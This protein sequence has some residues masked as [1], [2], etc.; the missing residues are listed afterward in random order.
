MLCQ[1]TLDT[2]L[3]AREIV[4]RNARYTP[5]LSSTRCSDMLGHPVHFK[6]ENLQR[7]G[8][9][10]IR[11]AGYKLAKLAASPD[12]PAPG[13]RRAVMAIS[14]GNHAQGVALAS[15]LNGI[16]STV[17]MPE[18][19]PLS[20][21]QATVRYGAEVIC[22]GQT[23][24]E[25]REHAMEWLKE[26][27]VTFVSPFDD[28]DI[29]TGQGSCGLEILEQLPE[30]K[31]VV[32][33]VGGG[34][35]ISGIAIAIKSQ[36]PDIKLIGIQ[37][38]SVPSLA[39]SF[40][41]GRIVH[42]AHRPTLADGIAIKQ[43]AER[44]FEV[45]RQSVDEML[46]VSEDAISRALFFAI[47][48]KH[49]IAEGA[50]VVGLAALLE[51]KIDA[52][53]PTVVVLSGGNIDVKLLDSIINKGMHDKGRFLIFKTLIEDSPGNLKKVLNLLAQQKGNVL[54]IQHARF[55]SN[56]PLN[57]TEI[58]VELETRDAAH[59]QEILA[60]LEHKGYHIQR[61]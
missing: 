23:F 10:K 1:V 53:G 16:Q 38:E 14:A 21:I 6:L 60:T 2:I 29:I 4:G 18:N 17:F 7:T 12:W 35:L 55:R 15:R 19:A 31:T 32:V 46:T 41:K 22:R 51:G 33:P 59:A 39:E 3:Q 61:L 56:I 9:F 43:P 25:T 45:I 42:P 30:V 52:T 27:P 37:T 28:D 47:Q 8:S 40:A 57:C 24:D 50:G 48:Y 49:I 36:R 58:E 5:L 11:G 26:N 34:G 13:H 44:N 20:K 54:H